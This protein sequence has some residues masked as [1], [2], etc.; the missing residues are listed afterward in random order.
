[1]FQKMSDNF[2]KMILC[3]LC[4]GS[5]F[6]GIAVFV[7]MIYPFNVDEYGWIFAVIAVPTVDFLYDGVKSGP[8]D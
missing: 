5:V 3:I 1:M 7:N 4:V 2:L 6:G 8:I